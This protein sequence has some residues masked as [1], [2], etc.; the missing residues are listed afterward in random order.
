MIKAETRMMRVQAKECQE[1]LT[2]QEE[3][4]RESM[5]LLRTWFWTSRFQYCGIPQ[6]KLY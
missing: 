1:R 2:T 6:I 3:A 5:A 4:I